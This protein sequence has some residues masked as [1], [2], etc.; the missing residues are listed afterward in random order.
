[1]TGTKPS[2]RAAIAGA[3]LGVAAGARA[4]TPIVQPPQPEARGF[5]ARA[6]DMRRK[7]EAAGDQGYGAVVAREGRI[8][9]QAPSA[10]VTRQDPT[11]HA[12]MEALRDA[13]S[14][15]GRRDLAGAV[16]YSSSRPCPMCEAAAY[17]AGIERMIHGE[18][19]TDAGRPRLTRC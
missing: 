11:A 17:W 5:M 8:I 13:A 9:G 15:L 12:E 10:V 1:M 16:L 2:R 3:L 4:E 7:A 6:F 19:L 14:R 18:G